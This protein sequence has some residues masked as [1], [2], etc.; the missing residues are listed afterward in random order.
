MSNIEP[1][2]LKPSNI[3][4]GTI[5]LA[6]APA[7]KLE[8]AYI[9][10]KIAP[11]NTNP[12]APVWVFVHGWGASAN[13]WVPLVDELKSQCEIWLLDLPSFGG[14]RQ[15]ANSPSTVAA[16]IAK[17]LPANTVLV[18]WSL[19][20]MLLPLIAQQIEQHWPTKTI[21]HCIG[22]AANAKFAQGDNYTAAMPAETFQTCC[23][24]FNAD[25]TT[26]WS[27][28]GLLQAQGDSN[29]KLV[30][31]QIKALHNAPMP[32]QFTAWQQALTWLGAID[33]RALLS[34]ITT[35]FLHL[36]GEGD[37]LVPA[38]AAVAM[39]GINPL[40]QTLVLASAGH[41]LH[42]SQPAEIAQIMLARVHAKRNKARVAKSFSNAAT[43]YDGV[44]HLQQKLAN[45][46]CEWV[47]EQAAMIADLGCG[48]GYCGLQLQRPEREIYS[49]DLAQGMLHTARSK[50]LAKQ[51]LFS[52]V[53]ADIECLPFISNGFDALVSGMSMQWC[54]D[55][56]T[57]FSEAHRVLKPNGEM[58]FS[59]LG[60]QTL[61]ELR[62]AW[63]EADIK[64][65][66][67]GCVHVNTFIELDR[68]EN[69]AKQA[70]F[71]VEQTSREIHV[72]TY[73]SV[74][75]LMRELKTIGAH[76]VNPGQE[77]GLTGK[78]RLKAMAQAYEQFRT[79]Q[80]VLPL[81]YEVG[82][83]RLVKV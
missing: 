29:R 43:E 72:L 64:L 83:Y 51:Q 75:P 10:K 50:A 8:A 24:N 25:P 52:G 69:A 82:F 73:D 32:E 3:E 77:Q 65:G 79:A 62:E 48:T 7:T 4:L 47:P 16:D 22:L 15:A 74:M 17:I 9:A 37:A 27:R 33:N 44:A 34:E 63:A 35:P 40:H 60:P 67:Q 2:N 12:N 13:T 14:N 1:S 66:R 59:T 31:R 45:I 5:P 11:N 54:E 71:V 20:G 41:V 28:F 57:V 49:L 58:V 18:G 68:V 61:F 26:T 55:L 56:P 70:G 19:G 81:T 30:S 76:N 36:F 21:S 78:A 23:A 39:A 38:D 53:C 42:F 46:L 6:E 80:G